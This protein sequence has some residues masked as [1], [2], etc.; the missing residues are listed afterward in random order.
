MTE[1][2]KFEAEERKIEILSA[3]N[4]S[5]VQCGRPAIFLAHRIAQTKNNIK[6]YGTAIIHHEKN[7]RPVCANQRCNDS[8]NIGNKP[9][10]VEE[11]VREIQAEISGHGY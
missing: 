1:R 9:M 8:V 4:Y 7:M 2:E 10:E 6:R 11:L 3:Y 5:C